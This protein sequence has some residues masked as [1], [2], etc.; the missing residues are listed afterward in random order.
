MPISYTYNL[1][2]IHVPKCAGTTIEKIIGACTSRELYGQNPTPRLGQH[3]TPQHLSYL[4][5][6]DTLNVNWSDYHAFSVVRNPYSRFVS[7]YNYRKDLFEKTKR[8]E[9]NPRTFSN[10]IEC[11]SKDP[12][13]RVSAYDGHLETQSSFL[14]NESGNIEPS[15]QIFKFEDLTSCWAMLEEKTGVKYSIDLWSR[16]SN[17]EIPYQEFYTSE[18]K[19]IIYNFYKEDFDNFGYSAEL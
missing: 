18:T 10:F 11:L 7:E 13:R 6:K 17:V 19:N 16:K 4:Q 14:K 15:I 2:F 12:S 3:T 5:L 8:P 1:I 9:F